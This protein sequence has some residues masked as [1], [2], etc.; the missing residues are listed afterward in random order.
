MN[1]ESSSPPGIRQL[2]WTP[3]PGATTIV[4]L[5]HG[6][7]MPEHPDHPHPTKDGHADPDLAPNGRE[8]AALAAER[9]AAEHDVEAFS[10][11]YVT[12]LRRTHQTAAP[13]AVRT[14]LDVVEVSDLREVHLGEWEGNFRERV[15]SGDPLFT[16]AIAEQRWDLIPGAED[17]DVFRTRIR[18]GIDHI[19]AANPSGRAVA[20]LHG[21]VIGQILAMATSA[22][23]FEFIA[24]DNCSISEVVVL[25]DGT[26]RIRR[27]N[28]TAHLQSLRLKPAD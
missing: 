24:S 4:M 10:A 28:D 7:S 2:P 3:P 14:G 18:S 13:F 8:Q 6:E 17:A 25:D 11:L 21:G 9:L 16:Q 5:R 20:V 26:W 12:S 22:G 15:A 19:V 23:A 1:D 27:F